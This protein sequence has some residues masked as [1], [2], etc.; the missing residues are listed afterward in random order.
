MHVEVRYFRL[1]LHQ[2]SYLQSEYDQRVRDLMQ[3]LAGCLLM[4]YVRTFLNYFLEFEN[5]LQIG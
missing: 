4:V 3:M 5:L 2:R 1:Q